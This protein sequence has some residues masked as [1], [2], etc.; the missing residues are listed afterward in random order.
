MEYL[1]ETETAQTAEQIKAALKLDVI[2]DRNLA[3]LITK[4]SKIQVENGR[5]SYKVRLL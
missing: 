2:A 4:T 5:Y 3:D 1:K